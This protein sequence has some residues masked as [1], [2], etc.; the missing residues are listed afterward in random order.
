MIRS[1]P[2]RKTIKL[3]ESRVLEYFQ[4]S[5]ALAAPRD[6]ADMILRLVEIADD[7]HALAQCLIVLL[8]TIQKQKPLLNP[9]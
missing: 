2:G 6:A 7:P 8:G 4:E 9:R 1:E 5:L 3:T